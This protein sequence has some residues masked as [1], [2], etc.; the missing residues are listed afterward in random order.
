M[1]D[2]C[3]WYCDQMWLKALHLEEKNG[4]IIVTDSR[5]SLDRWFVG[6]IKIENSI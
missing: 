5:Q 3:S 1:L 4:K 6:E 2:V